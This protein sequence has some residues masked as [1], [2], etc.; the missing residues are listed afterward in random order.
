MANLRFATGEKGV[1]S[2]GLHE[3]P[4]VGISR[5]DNKKGKPFTKSY[6]SG[7]RANLTPLA[8]HFVWVKRG[9]HESPRGISSSPKLEV[10]TGKKG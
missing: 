10:K 2:L 7:V 6:P 8:L 5:A 1:N 3:S 4:L 9:L